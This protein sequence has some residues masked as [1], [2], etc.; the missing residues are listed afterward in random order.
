MQTVMTFTLSQ[1]IAGFVA[2]CG[3]FTCVVVAISHGAKIVK[4]AKAPEAK[5]N[6]RITTLENRCNR[7]DEF[8]GKDKRRLDHIEDGNRVTQ[9]AILALLR[10]GIDGN[11]IDALKSAET[12]LHDFLLK[13]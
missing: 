5:Q 13:Q 12:E 7:F 11:D 3:G 9:R 6:E 10:H 4:A 2:V 1:L 8:F